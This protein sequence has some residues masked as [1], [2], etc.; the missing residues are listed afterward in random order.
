M[1][2]IRHDKT[3]MC[4][5]TKVYY[6]ACS[7]KRPPPSGDDTPLVHIRIFK[8]DNQADLPFKMPEIS[9]PEGE[10]YANIYT[11]TWV[12]IVYDYYALGFNMK[13]AWGVS[14]KKVLEPFFNENFS[15]KHL[16]CGVATGY[17]PAVALARPFR[18][19]SKQHITLFDINPHTLRAA[20]S[21][22]LSV[23]SATEVQCVEGDATEP[24]L[25]VLK[26]V[27]Y[28]SISMFNL[29]HCIPGGTGKLRAFATFKE[30]LSD[31]GVLTG[32][33]VLGAK[34]AANWFTKLYLRWYN[35]WQVLNNWDDNRDDFVDA[36]EQAFEEVE[37]WVI[38]TTLLFR[39]RKPRKTNG[40]LLITLN[41]T[42]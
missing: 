30:L 18:A 41:D 13:Y 32:C 27:K 20:Q 37:T 24:P 22:I 28:D 21:R 17:F 33:T 12:S 14:T 19:D 26:G 9:G 23:T 8:Q 38:G 40:E 7:D 42:V 15:R 34:H 11:R 29:F 16:D 10:V 1:D 35:W 31:D 4:V 36:L 3:Y 2:V 39:A 6:D 5:V 25:E